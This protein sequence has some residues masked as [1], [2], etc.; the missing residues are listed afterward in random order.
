[1]RTDSAHPLSLLLLEISVKVVRHKRWLWKAVENV[2]DPS[3]FG[4][5]Y[6]VQ[7]KFILSP[8]EQ[9]V[10]RARKKAE[11]LG[12]NLDQLVSEFLERFLAED[13]ERSI[14]EF[15]RLSGQGNSAGWTFDREEIHQRR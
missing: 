12:G 14:D 13:T 11:A 10:S 5:P 3:T 2:S 1:M 8:D 4:A 7:V 6:T 9:F 15:E